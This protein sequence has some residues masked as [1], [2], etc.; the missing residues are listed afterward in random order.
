MYGYSFGY[1]FARKSGSN[2]VVVPNPSEIFGA[3]LYD[4]WDITDSSTV[5]LSG[6]RIDAIDSKASGSTRQLTSSGANRPQIVSNQVN[7]LQVAN[8]DGVSEFMKVPSS[9]ALYNFL[10]D[11]SNGGMAIVVSRV[12]DAD[13][14]AF[15]SFIDNNN[16]SAANVGIRLS[17]DDRLIVP[18]NNNIYT[19]ITRGISGASNATAQQ[20]FDDIF[21][22][23]QFNVVTQIY[24]P[25][26]GFALERLNTIVN[27]GADNKANIY[28]NAP[29]TSDATFD[30]TVAAVGS[31]T[32]G[33]LKGDIAEI[34]ITTGQPTAL[35]LTQV[36]T[37]LTNKYGTFPIT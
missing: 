15:Y 14:D 32:F 12:T 26:S 31:L 30:L 37:Y 22:T 16:T 21:E 9:T 25:L 17:Y 29:S 18:K 6:S 5:T 10:H 34:I 33:F 1:N 4:W 7:G 11:Q 23:Q 13:P 20:D 35:Q 3:N 36:Q 19:S 24:D 27:F 8:F 2:I 28:T